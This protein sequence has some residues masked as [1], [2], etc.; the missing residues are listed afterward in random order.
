MSR[1][2]DYSAKI[3]RSPTKAPWW[4][5]NLRGLRAKTRTLINVTK[6][7]GQWNTHKETLTYYINELGKPNGLHG[8]GTA[9]RS[10][11]HQTVPRLMQIMAKRATNKVSIIKL[12]DDQ[13]TQTGVANL[14]D[15]FRVHSP[16]TDT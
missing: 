11:M 9:R 10:L 16:D 15:V 14:K 5:K 3:I 12:P 8:G 6:R 13:C 1:H 4:N 7:T 2:N